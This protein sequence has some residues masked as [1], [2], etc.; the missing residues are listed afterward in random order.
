MADLDV[1]LELDLAHNALGR[2][3]ERVRQRIKRFL[4]H[5]TEPRWDD[6]SSIIVNW[7]AAECSTIWQ[8]VVQVD[9]TFPRTGRRTDQH[10]R[11][12]ER[13]SRIPTP[14]LVVKALRFATH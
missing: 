9:P 5:P 6:V 14:E 4:A 12:A 8:A 2:L 3:P 10:G 13:W 11:I 1:N 7:D